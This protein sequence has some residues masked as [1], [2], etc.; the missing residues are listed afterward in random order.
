MAYP[1]PAMQ[2]RF[3]DTQRTDPWW[4]P[5]LGVLL[6]FT[7]F[8][9][10]STWRLWENAHY[11]YTENGAE[12]LSPMYSPLL[13]ASWFPS[14]WP[15]FIPRSPAIL[16]LWAPVG[17][18]FTCYYYRKAYYRAFGANPA[19]C[20]VGK[21]YKDYRG[22]NKLPFILQNAHRYFLIFAVLLIFILSYDAVLSYI[23]K[24]PAGGH[25]CGMGIGSIIL[26]INPILLGAYTFGCHSLR[27]I[28]GGKLDCFSCSFSAR[29]RHTIWEK[30]TVLNERHQMWAWFSLVWVGFTDLYVRM[31]STGA[32]TDVRLF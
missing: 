4:L 1:V 16:I 30:L 21:P 22:E 24:T 13:P 17:F 23:W 27:H 32:W 25:E 29:C 12:Y 3:G 5:P 20:A 10:Y 14:W 31:V 2:D 18:R 8:L 19:A 6:G 9:V 26:T 11:L 7:A 28:T 15:N